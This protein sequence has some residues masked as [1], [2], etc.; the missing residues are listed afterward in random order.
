MAHCTNPLQIIFALRLA[1][2]LLNFIYLIWTT[3][4]YTQIHARRTSNFTGLATLRRWN[5]YLYQFSNRFDVIC[6]LWLFHII[7]QFFNSTTTINSVV[8]CYCA[9]QRIG[10]EF[11]DYSKESTIWQYEANLKKFLMCITWVWLP[12]ELSR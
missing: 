9:N 11:M 10:S 7:Q 8:L 3:M 5:I 12:N 4:K 6:I 2:M 1:A